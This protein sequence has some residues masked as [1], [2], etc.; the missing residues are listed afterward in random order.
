MIGEGVDL[1]REG[2]GGPDRGQVDR[3]S[4]PARQARLLDD[5]VRPMGPGLLDRQGRAARTGFEIGAE[6]GVEEH[7]LAI[8][9]QLGGGVVALERHIIEIDPPALDADLGE[10]RL[11]K[12]VAPAAGGVED[13]GNARRAGRHRAMAARQERGPFPRSDD[14]SHAER[15]GLVRLRIGNE[16]SVAGG[17]R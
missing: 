1:R 3:L 15:I 16:V 7:P 5:D 4:L 14:L 8:D 13:G 9:E 17:Q 10:H 11:Q 6:G 2:A 12:D